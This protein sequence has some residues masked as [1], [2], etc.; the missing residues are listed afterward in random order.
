MSNYKKFF[1]FFLICFSFFLSYTKTFATEFSPSS[2]GDLF[3]TDLAIEMTNQI[4]SRIDGLSTSTGYMSLFTTRG[5]VTAPWVKNTNVWT[6]RGTT[7]ID[8]SGQSVWNSTGGYTRSGTMISPKH[9]VFA[10]HYPIAIGATIIFIDRNGVVVSRTLASS[11]SAGRDITVGI[12]N[13]NV[14]DT[15]S[16]Y[17]VLTQEQWT[18][19]LSSTGVPLVLL[20][21]E[22]KMII[23]NLSNLSSLT[24]NISCDIPPENSSRYPFYES[25]VDG[26]SGNPIFSIINNQPVLMSHE[27]FPCVGPSYTNFSFEI[28]AA[29]S[30]LGTSYQ[31]STYNTACFNEVDL[32]P[33]ITTPS[34]FYMNEDATI[35]TQ[36]GSIV[37]T[38]SS[39]FA[40]EYSI[41]EG[42]TNNTFQISTTTGMITRLNSTLSYVTDPLFNLTIQAYANDGNLFGS[43]RI[44][45]TT[46]VI[47]ILPPT[48]PITPIVYFYSTS[49]TAWGTVGNWWA[50]YEHTIP[51][52]RT[53]NSTDTVFII[54]PT[55]PTVDLSSI[56]VAPAY[57][58]STA[59]GN[60]IFN[61]SG[62]NKAI[63]PIIFGP[64]TFNSSGYS[65]YFTGT[66]TGSTTFNQG[67]LN[68]GNITGDVTFN[69]AKNNNLGTYPVGTI[70]G[71]VTLNN[72][73]TGLARNEGVVNGNVISNDNYPY[74]SDGSGTV[75]NGDY[76]LN[77]LVGTT[78]LT[79][80]KTNFGTVNGLVKNSTG[81]T[82]T[83]FIFNSYQ[84]NYGRVPGNAV[85]KDYTAGEVGGS[86][87]FGIVN[88]DA[89]FTDLT[90]TTTMSFSMF[91]NWTCTVL[92]GYVKN[93]ERQ[94][95]DKYVFDRATNRGR[96]V[97]E[98]IFVGFLGG[99]N[100]TIVGNT[101]FSNST[102]NQGVITGNVI[103]NNNSN[104]TGQR[105]NRVN[106][107]SDITGDVIFNGDS[108]NGGNYP[109][110]GNVTLN[111]RS[112]NV[113]TITGNVTLN[114]TSSSN[115]GT[116]NGNA[117][118]SSSTNN[119]I[120][121]LTK[122]YGLVTGTVKG[123]DGIDINSWIFNTGSRNETGI[124]GS[125]TFNGTSYNMS[126]T[127]AT[128]T[129]N[130]SSYNR[131]T[132]TANAIFNGNLSENFKVSGA[133]TYRGIVTGT[134]TRHYSTTT[135]ASSRDFIT[136][137]PWIIQSD[138]TTVTMSDRT[139]YDSS[140]TFESLN[141]GLFT[142][143]IA[144]FNSPIT[145]STGRTSFTLNAPISN[146]S[147]IT[148]TSLG[149]NYGLTTDYGSTVVGTGTE[150][151]SATLSGLQ[152]GRKTYHYNAFVTT[153]GGTATS[154]DGTFE[155]GRCNSSNINQ[156]SS[157]VTTTDTT[158]VEP[159]K[160]P[161]VTPPVSTSTSNESLLK[162]LE[163]I[164][165]NNKPSTVTPSPSF[166]EYLKLGSEGTEV[167]RLQNF[168]ITK[169][170]S[171]PAGA[172]GYFGGQTQLAL[173]N[174][175]KDKNITPTGTFG[176]ITR[177]SVNKNTLPTTPKPTNTTKFIFNNNLKLNDV[178]EDVRQLQIY[179]NNNGFTVSETGTG[180]KG[181]E[182]T[183]YG[184]K[185]VQAV[186]KLQEAHRSEILT[187]N[188][189]KS[190]TGM[191]YEVTREWLNGN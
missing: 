65:L 179:L 77:G 97:G 159:T 7:P 64:S 47:N 49:S 144:L 184:Q 56:W 20:D 129:F 148:P 71:N 114:G 53:P 34:P 191:F 106:Y 94:I 146:G 39:G 9:I 182:S 86:A 160:T 16:Y 145:E 21:Q 3:S 175:Q 190:G 98:A 58:N 12:L 31:L 156:S 108:F 124:V 123:G 25:I 59:T 95:V 10:T 32:K 166:S 133:T 158:I 180:S 127:T 41:T 104:A 11:T 176:P 22:D 147:V 162:E 37:A 57:I 50:D 154:S 116:I 117:I 155:T 2:C 8:F 161:S 67:T 143:L 13:E 85:F 173:S 109:I 54:G 130:D 107:F 43:N 139:K 60:L 102:V 68:N 81:Q 187:P 92:G 178:S 96:V 90:G 132:T 28:N 100:G 75:I 78:T 188:G 52:T 138:N 118:Y 151:L 76:I 82:V 45:T 103:F 72:T 181:N 110:I 121:T 134:K 105:I 79:I 36:V 136:D 48:A 111:D 51:M 189:F 135:D 157:E 115:G 170:Y 186:K 172:T 15:V 61:N 185:T 89:V 87:C 69:N 80:N 14:P 113:G 62:S 168:L 93:N 128:T 141:G 44:S 101:I 17:P 4:D 177:D 42:N 5:T 165:K 24:G 125:S 137:G 171:L 38:S 88:G 150:T 23:S 46:V 112:Q 120:L 55:V 169:G 26:D 73:T 40:I 18:N 66:S 167:T 174:Y 83:N 183:F 153:L 122:G 126:T 35:G 6:S 74:F 140:T 70:N 119:G 30:S 131:G 164:L 33:I 152:C 27:L 99:N 1:V 163:D 29:M 91:Q 149:F 142:G 84:N 63:N 19:Y